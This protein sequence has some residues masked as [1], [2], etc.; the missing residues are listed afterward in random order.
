MRRSK[1]LTLFLAF[2]ALM[3]LPA[4]S[5]CG[6]ETPGDA[7][8]RHLELLNDRQWD[9]FYDMHAGDLPD[10][11]EFIDSLEDTF[12]EEASISD[13][14]ILKEEIDGDNAAVEVR[15]VINLPDTGEQEVEE[16]VK[17]VREGGGAWK[18]AEG[19]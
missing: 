1:R 10:R 18:I 7:V 19:I 11:Q 6:E 14:E 5:G 9:E 2:L 15:Y 8:E 16:T 17:L 3:A 12:P 4:L 13:I